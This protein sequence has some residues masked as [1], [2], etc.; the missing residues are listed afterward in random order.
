MSQLTGRW[1]SVGARTGDD[2]EDDGLDGAAG[3]RG[4]MTV[5]EMSCIL[6]S[7]PMLQRACTNLP[8][9]CPLEV[10]TPGQRTGL[11][12]MGDQMMAPMELARQ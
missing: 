3:G 6:N 2:V 10:Q 4:A 12:P 1:N 9:P 7:V 5:G 8:L 11:R